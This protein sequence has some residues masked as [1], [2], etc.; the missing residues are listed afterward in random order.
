MFYSINLSTFA[1]VKNYFPQVGNT[2]SQF[3][4]PPCYFVRRKLIA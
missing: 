4:A 2:L 1:E 3:L